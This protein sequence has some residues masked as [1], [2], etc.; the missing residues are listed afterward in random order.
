MKLTTLL[1]TAVLALPVAGWAADTVKGDVANAWDATKDAATRTGQTIENGAVKAGRT[2]EHG[3]QKTGAVVERT[4][5]PTPRVT[6]TDGQIMKPG[7]I[8]AGSDL[9]IRNRSDTGERFTIRGHGL[10]ERVFV[11][12][13]ESRRMNLD[14]SAGDYSLSAPE[15]GTTRL[16]VR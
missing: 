16:R 9:I 13:G 7:N 11:P 12:A 3:V 6:L 2:I 14:L 5:E 15:S 1:L 8:P 10:D 4:I